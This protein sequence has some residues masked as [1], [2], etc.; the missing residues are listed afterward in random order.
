[1][2]AQGNGKIVGIIMAKFNIISK[3]GASVRYTGLSKI[4]R[5]LYGSVGSVLEFSEISVSVSHKLG[6]SGDFVDYRTDD[7]LSLPEP[8]KQ[9]RRN[10][11]G[12]AFVYAECSST[13]LSSSL[14][15]PAFR[16][17]VTEDNEVL[18][19]CP[20]LYENVHGIARK[21]TGLHG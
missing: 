2:V 5:F 9:A 12:A 3:D 21:D 10:E 19:L 4:Q 11:Y 14:R 15:L 18:L 1:M 7:Y 17:I 8:R 16:D 20:M 6:D 13:P